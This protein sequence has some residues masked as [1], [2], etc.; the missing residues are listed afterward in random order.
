M[1]T[2]KNYYETDLEIRISEIREIINNSD[3]ERASQL[4]EDIHYVDI[5]EALDHFE[6]DE[7]KIFI[8]L[9]NLEDVAGILENSWEEMHTLISSFFTNDELISVFSYMN[10]ADIA[11]FL[12]VMP[13]HRR[14]DILKFM[15]T[16]ESNILKLILSFD[17]ES[18]GVRN[19]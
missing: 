2:A 3:K 19:T 13:T 5:V 17:E 16:S 12:G 10:N 8:K 15:K 6:E 9:L 11:D 1:D 14:K 18:A 7:I 4:C